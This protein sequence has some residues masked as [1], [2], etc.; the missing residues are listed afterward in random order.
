MELCLT[1][2]LKRTIEVSEDAFEE[3]TKGVHEIMEEYKQALQ[4]DFL[5]L[6]DHSDTVQ[7]EQVTRY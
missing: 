3:Y 7:T 5:V 1:V 4:E 2:T 6:M